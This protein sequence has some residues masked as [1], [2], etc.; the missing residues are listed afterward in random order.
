MVLSGIFF[1][2]D[3]YL[4]QGVVAATQGLAPTTRQLVHQLW[5]GLYGLVVAGL[6]AYN[7]LDP[8][9]LGPKTR[10]A[11]LAGV[12]ALFMGKLF[13]L[14]FMVIEEARRLIGWLWASLS[15]EAPPAWLDPAR[16]AIVS[17]IGAAA[18]AVPVLATGWGILS[19]AHDY[20]VRRETIY[21]PELPEAFDGLRLLQLSDIHAGSF[22]SP[23][24]VQRGIELVVRQ[25]ADLICFTGDLVNNRADEMATYQDLFAQIRAPMGVYSIL[26]N[27]DY[28]DYVAWPSPEA[29]RDNLRRLAEVHRAMGWDLL[30]NQHRWL[31][32][33][34]A[35]IALL[36]IENWGAKANFPQYGKLSEAYAGTEEAPVHILLSHDPSHWQAEVRPDYPKI[37]LTLSGHTHGMQFGVEIP[38]LAKWSPVQYVYPEW[39]GLYREGGQYLYVNRGFGYLGFPGRIGIPP[40]ITVLTLKRGQAPD[41]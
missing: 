7:L 10:M 35:R 6:L 1:L 31:Q 21:L 33:D 26:G 22:W 32:R 41:R 29:K 15:G 17:R 37:D 36:G 12:F 19:G 27:H 39:G 16:S 20:R 14:F 2:L 8:Y 25:E 34:G 30:L 28:G 40:E 5:W 4:F 38:G 11:I 24:A 9:R 18:A 3:L 23:Q 13:M